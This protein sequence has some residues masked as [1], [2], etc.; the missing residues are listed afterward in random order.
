MNRR[1]VL[2]GAGVISTILMS[3]ISVAAEKGTAPT[4]EELKKITDASFDC[5]KT[6]EACETMC[7]ELLAKGDTSMKNCHATLQNMLAACT[8]MTKVGSYDTAKPETIRR[9]AAV[10]SDLCKECSESCKV[11]AEHHAICK[12]CMDSCNR[13]AN[14]CDAIA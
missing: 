12:S 8:A 7:I 10:C 2:V 1:E 9:L 4:R 14:A 6:G 13:C 11:H 3:K 5:L